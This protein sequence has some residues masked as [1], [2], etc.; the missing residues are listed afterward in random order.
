MKPE[1]SQ[2][3]L[4]QQ[5]KPLDNSTNPWSNS[6]QIKKPSSHQIKKI[7][8]SVG[9]VIL[10]LLA[11]FGGAALYSLIDGRSQTINNNTTVT[12]TESEAIAA[13]AEKVSASVVSI[14]VNGTSTTSR[15]DFSW[16]YGGGSR[17]Y[18]TSSAGTGIIISSDGYIMTNRH[19][20]SDNVTS[21]TVVLGDGTEYSDV[22]VVGAD[23]LND[24]AFLKIQNVSGLTAAELSDSSSIK[25]G[26]KVI[27]VG[28]ALGEYQNSVTSGIISATGRTI[29]AEVD[30][31]TGETETLTNL[32]Q[33]DAAIN[34]GNSGGPLVTL[35]GK[36]IGINTAIIE[37]AQGIGFAIPI[38]EASGV[39]TGVLKTGTVKRAY[40]GVYYT[41]LSKS[42]AKEYNLPVS[43][44]A[45]IYTE[46]GS[47]IVSGGP[48]DTAGLKSGDIVVAV[49]GKALTSDYQL[50]S[51]TAARQP[52]DEVTL[53]VLRGSD[54]LTITV[55][56]GTYQ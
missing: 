38:S 34:E 24:L 26:T 51:V 6:K 42:V 7:L 19:I 2:Q 27:A 16:F 48:A 37:D 12:S 13:A 56:L 40:L 14:V 54:T 32:L 10:A 30:S 15:D 11:G 8:F 41:T 5:S 53:T 18:E 22:K 55:E 39:I 49:D 45:Y 9:M 31:E 52:G 47:A 43:D 23:P 4:D 29:T 21:V 44:G 20:L 3:T 28:N 25:V 1:Q 17:T 46:D 36:V 50:S 35:D 33:T